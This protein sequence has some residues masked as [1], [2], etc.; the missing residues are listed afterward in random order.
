MGSAFEHADKLGMFLHFKTLEH[1]NQGTY[2]TMEG[3]GLYTKLYFRETNCPI[4]A[5]FGPKL[6]FGRR[7]GG[8]DRGHL[9]PFPLMLRSVYAW[10]NTFLP[11]ILT[12][13]IS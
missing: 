8:L 11:L 7:D 1:E 10:R 12:N 4:W 9:L 13:I 5:S 6:E 2:S 3:T